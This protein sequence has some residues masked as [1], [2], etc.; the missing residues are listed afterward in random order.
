MYLRV[1]RSL[2][3]MPFK[4]FFNDRYLNSFDQPDFRHNMISTFNSVFFVVYPEGD[5][6]MGFINNLFKKG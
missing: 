1:C 5:V 3:P 4:L 2:N 6:V